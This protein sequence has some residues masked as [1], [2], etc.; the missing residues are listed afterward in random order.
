MKSHFATKHTDTGANFP[1]WVFTSVAHWGE[2][3]AGTWTLKVADLAAGTSGTLLNWNVKAYGYNPAPTP[4]AT[5]TPSPTPSPTPVP[6]AT[7][8]A[9][10]T[11]APSATP[12]DTPT[13]VPPSS[14]GDQWRLSL[15]DLPRPSPSNRETSMTRNSAGFHGAAGEKTLAAHS[16]RT[17]FVTSGNDEMIERLAKIG[18]ALS[19]PSRVRLLFALRDAERCVC[20]LQE[21][22]GLAPSTTSR[23]LSIPFPAQPMIRW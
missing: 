12:T 7:P 9:T 11:A 8:T 17:Y 22:L 18:N 10:P 20:Q 15:L 23:H 16:L 4:T 21:F 1:N 5:P 6:T 2:N 3:P 14:R 19:D 13:P